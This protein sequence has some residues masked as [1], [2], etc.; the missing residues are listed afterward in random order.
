VVLVL[1]LEDQV[2]MVELNQVVVKDQQLK[3]LI[4]QRMNRLIT[5]IFYNQQQ[6]YTP[7]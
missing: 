1:A 7:S 5:H 3:K 2:V 6:K 4:K